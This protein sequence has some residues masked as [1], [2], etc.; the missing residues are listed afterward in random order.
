MAH[1]ITQVNGRYEF[2][3]A[4][5]AP[6]H[7]LGQ[8]LSAIATKDEIMKAAG[9]EW[10]VYAEPLTLAGDQS[11]VAGWVANVRSDTREVL[12]VVSTEYRLI[13]IGDAFNFVEQLAQSA[14]AK[15]HTAGSIRRGRQVFASAK[16]PHSIVVLPGDVVDQY[17]LLVNSYDGSTGFQLRWTPIRVVCNNT[18]TAALAGRASYQYSVR[19]AGDLGAQLTEARK[20]LGMAARYFDVAGDTYR[21]LAAKD[22]SA[23]EMDR[24]LVKFL[25]VVEP[26]DTASRPEGEAERGR[27]L[28]SRDRIRVLFE[29]GQGTE[30]PGVRGTAWGLYNAATEWIDRVRTAKKDG[31]LRAGAAEAVVL[32]VGQELRDRAMG[33]VLELVS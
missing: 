18:L 20:A 26:A 32:G 9:L 28:A 6:W 3:Y 4:G 7:G 33:A 24:F 16:L 1:N 27:I 15:Y 25:P 11:P 8:P 30:I 31:T 14:G 29:Q 10:T 22:L 17:L 2:A 21:A 19:H 23:M 5:E 13:Q 12:G